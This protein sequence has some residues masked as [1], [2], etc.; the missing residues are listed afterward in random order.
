MSRSLTWR[1]GPGSRLGSRAGDGPRNFFLGTLSPSL[2]YAAS[3][4]GEFGWSVRNHLLDL[5]NKTTITIDG[6]RLSYRP[7][8][9]LP[10]R[11]GFQVELRELCEYGAAVFAAM[12]PTVL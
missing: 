3:V 2:R 10:Q 5:S 8:S 12:R 7:P 4:V 9:P 11:I 1:E 6:Q